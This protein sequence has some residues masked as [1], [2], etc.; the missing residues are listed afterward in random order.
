MGGREGGRTQLKKRIGGGRG[1]RS[2]VFTCQSRIEVS[3]HEA[4][5]EY[6]SV[7]VCV[8]VY[9]VHVVGHFSRGLRIPHLA[10]HVVLVQ[11]LVLEKHVKALL[12][13]GERM[14]RNSK[15]DKR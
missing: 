3:L 5:V 2:L 15:K 1:G 9:N 10:W 8:C 13:L 6:G 7:C 14:P 11:S 12:V 4:Q